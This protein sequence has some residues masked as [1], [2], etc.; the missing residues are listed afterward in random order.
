MID[1]DT[2][3]RRIAQGTGQV[4]A[5][6]VIR[7]VR[8]FDLVTGDLIETDIA[9]TGDTIVGTYGAYEA[10]RVIEGCGRIAVPRLD[11]YASAYRVIPVTQRSSTAACCRTV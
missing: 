6:L 2:I 4:L 1:A 7:D 9:I 8:L 5:D 10:R 11:R 3:S